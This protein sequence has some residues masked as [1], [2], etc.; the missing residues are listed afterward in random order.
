MQPAITA[1]DLPGLIKGQMNFRVSKGTTAA[2]TGK[3]RMLYLN[4]FR[5]ANRCSIRH[6][7]R[8]SSSREI[9]EFGV[10]LIILCPGLHLNM[11]TQILDLL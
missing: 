10:P 8:L 9:D 2:I 11:P 3:R 5:S 6:G 7:L 1:I 4:S